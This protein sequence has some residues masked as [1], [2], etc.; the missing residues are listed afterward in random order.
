MSEQKIVRILDGKTSRRGVLKSA[1]VTL[2]G[3]ALNGL[4]AACNLQRDN[5]AVVVK[6]RVLDSQSLFDPPLVKVSR[7]AT[8][9]FQNIAIYPQTVTCDPAKAGQDKNVSLPAGAS[10]FDSGELY[11]GQTWSYTF[12]APGTYVYFNRYFETPSGVGTVQVV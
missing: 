2:G 10:P 5:P 3:L 1:A 9:I 4:L 7:G 8:V 11:P 6:I 12:T